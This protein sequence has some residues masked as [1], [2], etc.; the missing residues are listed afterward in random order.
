MK[1]NQILSI[2][3][4]MSLFLCN[5]NMLENE[6]LFDDVKTPDETYLPAHIEEYGKSIAKELY[7]TVKNL[8]KSG[9]DYSDANSSTTFKERFFNDFD[10]ASPTK[11]KSATIN[12]MQL[13]PKV[14]AER[15][16]NLTQIQ[17]KFID[18]IIKECD[19][20]ESYTDIA[21]RL[22]KVNKDIYSEVPEIQQERLFTVTAVLYYGIKEI[23]NLEEQGLM[24]RTPR[25]NMQYLRL[26]SGNNES[27][28]SLG[29][30]CRKFLATTWAIA[31]GEPTPVGEIV[32]SVATVI[33][34][35]ILLYEVVVCAAN[36]ID[37]S[38]KY[39]EC[40]SKGS[41]PSWKCNDCRVYCEG[42]HVWDC[43]RPY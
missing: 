22:V 28:G 30:S 6:E 25:S 24:P 40:V 36:T 5:C 1:K 27:G 9:V 18:R 8:S 29:G 2:L 15:V 13:T 16:N 21:K 11:T 37:C 10:K 33:I 17:I 14:F 20:S 12:P 42:Q 7:N 34:G 3:C 38:A 41:L 31:L 43:P 23:Q 19:K 26:K 35:G 39:V 4:L 32:A